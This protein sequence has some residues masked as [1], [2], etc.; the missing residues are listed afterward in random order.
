[1]VHCWMYNVRLSLLSSE[2]SLWLVKLFS[3]YIVFMYSKIN[4]YT[5]KS[6]YAIFSNSKNNDLLFRRKTCSLYLTTINGHWSEDHDEVDVLKYIFIFIMNTI[7]YQ[8]VINALSYSIKLW[9]N[10][11]CW[12][13]RMAL[14]LMVAFI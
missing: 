1:M 2:S 12:E 3:K 8:D 10:N 7:R 14:K 9:T 4:W 6:M 11:G 13:K 5:D